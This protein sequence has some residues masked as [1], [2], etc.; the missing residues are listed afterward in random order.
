MRLAHLR[1]APTGRVYDR[2][3]V[4]RRALG[5][6]RVDRLTVTDVAALW[7]GVAPGPLALV[8]K[9]AAGVDAV[10]VGVRARQARRV[11]PSIAVAGA[12]A[13]PENVVGDVPVVTGHQAFALGTIAVAGA[14][15][16]EVLCGDSRV[17]AART[18]RG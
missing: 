3:L 12:G 18:A 16:T 7:C 1:E 15:E 4:G 17:I 5:V 6:A 2:L 13:E 14:R 9:A 8:D 11:A 10:V